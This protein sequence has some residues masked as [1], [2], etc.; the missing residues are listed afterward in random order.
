MKF[1]V[2]LDESKTSKA[3]LQLAKKHAEAFKADLILVTSMLT[4]TENEKEKIKEAEDQ[5]NNSK[6]IY[7]KDG[8][9]C[10]THLLIRGLSAGE[11]LVDF[12]HEQKADLLFIGIKRRS[13]VEKLVFGSTAQYVILH[14]DCPVVTVK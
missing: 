8:I 14:A 12:A 11:D 7:E 2:C 5:L 3:A 13:K 6:N 9:P 1:M 10:D 4:G